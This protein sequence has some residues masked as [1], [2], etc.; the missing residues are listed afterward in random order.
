LTDFV[1]GANNY[2]GSRKV[3]ARLDARKGGGKSQ[4]VSFCGEQREPE[5][6][7]EA[8]NVRKHANLRDKERNGKKKGRCE[9][10]A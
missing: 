6:V 4:L 7:Q 8:T 3:W 2:M 10:P 5:R 9:N 1:G